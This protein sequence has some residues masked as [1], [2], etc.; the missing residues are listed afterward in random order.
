[1]LDSHS[2]SKLNR[3]SWA[4]PAGLLLILAAS[5]APSRGQTEDRYVGAKACAECH[6]EIH[7]EW[8]GSQHGATMQEAT[9]RSV[10]GDFSESKITLHGATYLLHVR[11][12]AGYYITESDLTRNAWEHH[13]DYTLGNRWFQHY[14]ATLPDGRIVVLPPTWDVQRKKWEYVSDIGNPEE[15]S[16]DATP[17][18]NKACFSCHASQVN[19]NFDLEDLRYRTTWK[20]LGANCETCHGP[21]NE[22]VAWTTSIRSKDGKTR[23]RAKETVVNPT[24]LDA[25]RSTMICAQC[26]SLRDMYADGFAAGANYYDFFTPVMEYRLP[27]S[28][29]PAYWADGRPRQLSNEALGLWQSQCYLSGGATCV[30]CHSRP[31]SADT[32]RDTLRGPGG[33][34]RCTSCHKKVA[35]DLSAHTHHAAQSAGSSCV[36]CHMPATIADL[37]TRMRDHSIS[38]PVPENTIRHEIPNACNV[39][40]Q[41]K[42]AAWA[43]GVMNQ[44]HGE[45]SR[46]KL[47]DRADVFAQARKGDTAAIPKLLKILSEPSGGELTRANAVGYLGTF[48][49]DP[50]AY[51]AVV[52]ALRDA[53]P[54]LRA[55]AAT[56]IK[57]SA[58]QRETVATDLVGLLNDPIRT[59]R[60]SAAI[61]MVAMGVRPFPGEDGERYERAKQLYR[62]RAE[63]NSDDAQQQ[64][65]AGKFFFLAGDMASAAKAFRVTLKLDAA[66]PAQYYL[67][68]SLAEAGDYSAAREVL[69]GIPAG[70]QQYEAAQRVLAEIEAR[71]LN[72]SEALQGRTAN[73]SNDE[74]QGN[75]LQGQLAYQN[76]Q[77]G[78][79]LKDLEQALQA[80]PEAAW[81]PKAQI[82]R[83]ICLEKVGR[84]S[85]AEAALRALSNQPEARANVEL[86]LA[87]T[88]LLYETGRAQEALKRLDELLVEGPQTP[89]VYFW[90]A[91]VLLQLQRTNDAGSAA[92]QAIAL[93]P[94]FPE[95]HNLLLKIYQEQ[96]RGKEAAQQ[97]EWL[98][99]YQRRKESH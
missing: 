55:T 57:P 86:Q 8:A 89:M 98:R 3:V 99:D 72:H 7:R 22:H 50:S 92:E 67:G 58:A 87:L 64:L 56:A 94:E 75:F 15:A 62:A 97:A 2:V 71:D 17:L 30:M 23:A 38:I 27:A 37:K 53:A 66:I 20:D 29:D 83:A 60:M 10:K 61:A 34:A 18:W 65:A 52:H 80:T 88:E 54:L 42:D 31:H 73:H 68:R 36:E 49:N 19:K 51:A 81:A 84:T 44:W 79:A 77:Y 11:G 43:V 26:H 45:K 93:L 35:V 1:M 25:P 33:N 13:V 16:G 5:L 74:A 91:K 96:G 46:Q 9:D 28:D 69:S 90:R 21:G 24:R 47:I 14:L 40:H 59:V 95:A 85:E 48:P 41:D 12:K 78:A 4:T 63:L 32:G 76:Q 39:C 82:V 6:T 70:N